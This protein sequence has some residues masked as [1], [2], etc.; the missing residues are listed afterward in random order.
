MTERFEK[1]QKK[2]RHINKNF[3]KIMVHK[4][5]QFFNES[6]YFKINNN[7]NNNNNC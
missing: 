4:Q 6:K 2:S 3:S 1:R 7:Y 5:P